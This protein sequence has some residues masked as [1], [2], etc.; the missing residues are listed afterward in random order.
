MTLATELERALA[1]DGVL[2]AAVRASFPNALA[3]Y[4]FGSRI[5]GTPR[6]D[7]D[8]DLAVLVAGYAP[9]LLLWDTASTLAGLIGCPVDLLDLRLAST[10]MQ[11]Q[12]ITTGRCLWALQP[13]AVQF[14]L[15]VLREKLAL[16]A[17]RAG[18]LSDI[19]KTGKIYG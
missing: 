18:L 12:V 8:L 17:A 5:Q 19:E 9:P 13:D 14:E 15:F 2:V 3:L 7:S 1:A 16:D 4:A 11:H 10:V 6:P